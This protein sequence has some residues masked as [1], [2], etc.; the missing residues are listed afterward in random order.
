MSAYLDQSGR[1]EKGV[2]HGRVFAG[3]VQPK[4]SAGSDPPSDFEGIRRGL[5]P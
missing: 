4:E 1:G 2:V 5:D 3:N